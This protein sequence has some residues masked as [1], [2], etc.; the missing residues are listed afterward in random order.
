MY[1][2]IQGEEYPDEL[3]LKLT[4]RGLEWF[5]NNPCLRREDLKTYVKLP[6]EDLEVELQS[7]RSEIEDLVS[8][9]T[10]E[11]KPVRLQAGSNY[12][13]RRLLLV[14]KV[15]QG[16]SSLGN[17]LLGD[18]T[19]RVYDTV[20]SGTQESKYARSRGSNVEVFDTQGFRDSDARE[21]DLEMSKVYGITSLCSLLLLLANAK[22]YLGALI[23]TKYVSYL[24]I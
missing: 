11:R 20:K 17:L 12:P 8:R 5:A 7:K 4:E 14:G 22:Q 1:P 6:Q 21:V 16:K 24:Q 2:P 15:G 3:K 9:F 13:P 23:R 19:F 10:V 18:N